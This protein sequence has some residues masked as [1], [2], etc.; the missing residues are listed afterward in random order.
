[1]NYKIGYKVKPQKITEDGV[2]IF[3]D[4]INE[5]P[6]SQKSCQA[7]G[8]KWSKSTSTC[9]IGGSS[10]SLSK[11]LNEKSNKIGGYNN[12]T[13]GYV[14]S[15]VIYGNSNYLEGNNKNIIVNGD[16]NRI[17]GG[18]Y[19]SSIISGDK[20]IISEDVN[21]SSVL[22]GTGAICIRDAET[23]IGGFYED[24]LNRLSG[25]TTQFVTQSSTFN[26]QATATST[27]LTKLQVQNGNDYFEVHPL[28]FMYV[29]VKCMT[30]G[31]GVGKVSAGTLNATVG[32]GSNGIPSVRAQ[33]FTHEN[34][35]NST[36]GNKTY[37]I[38]NQGSPNPGLV[39]R[40]QGVASETVVMTATVS[41][42]ETI[43]GDL[44]DLS[45]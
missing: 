15:S 10:N 31:N 8:Y 39:I 34:N 3:T 6:A 32:V 11:K 5:V 24:G 44:T 38:V 29:T 23:V 13:G 28:S 9:V 37:Y 45:N 2:V 40:S 21:N 30:S 17:K 43:H 25:E 36:Y 1:M 33:T 16:S 4:G 35:S 42:T 26:M 18:V 22:S 27:S 7:Y 41:I 20:N 14:E 19:N 12:K